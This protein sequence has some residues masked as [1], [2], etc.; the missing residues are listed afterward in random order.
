MY[1]VLPQATE[2]Y[3]K[4]ISGEISPNDFMTMYDPE[5]YVKVSTNYL[6]GQKQYLYMVTFTV[7]PDCK[8]DEDHIEQLIEKTAKRK[9]LEVTRFEYVKEYR[10]MVN[11]TGLHYYA[12][13]VTGKH[14]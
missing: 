10:D 3:L 6:L 14:I 1:K 9:A 12:A 2:D 5:T 8:Y 11:K 7:S 13:I 4:V